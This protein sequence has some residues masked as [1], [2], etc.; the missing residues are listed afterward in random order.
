MLKIRLKLKVRLKPDTTNKTEGPA[1]AGHYRFTK[2]S[3]GPAEA[4]HCQYTKHANAGHYQTIHRDAARTRKR[5]AISRPPPQS[6]MNL[7]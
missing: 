1:K 6:A 5:A 4:E 2:Q 3:D 7:K